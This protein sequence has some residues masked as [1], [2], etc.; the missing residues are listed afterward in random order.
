MASLQLFMLRMHLLDSSS[1]YRPAARRRRFSSS[2]SGSTYNIAD[3]NN[4]CSLS[5]IVNPSLK[6][7]RVPSFVYQTCPAVED[8]NETDTPS[9]LAVH[10]FEGLDTKLRSEQPVSVCIEKFL[11]F[12]RFA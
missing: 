2:V 11:S 6:R 4:N 8:G 5:P 7:H 9:Q 3:L 1:P 12:R 10:V